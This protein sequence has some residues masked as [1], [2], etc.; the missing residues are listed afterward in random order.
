MLSSASPVTTVVLC[1]CAIDL[2]HC[3]THS[4]VGRAVIVVIKSS[5]IP[6]LFKNCKLMPA[7]Q[8][9]ALHAVLS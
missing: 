7:L 6:V 9:H 5:P 2:M 4:D 3:P 1:F 8:Y